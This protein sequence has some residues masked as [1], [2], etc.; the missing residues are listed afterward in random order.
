M[1]ISRE[2]FVGPFWPCTK[3]HVLGLWPKGSKS[4]PEYVCGIMYDHT[5]TSAGEI[6]I[7]R[8]EFS[9]IIEPGSR[10]APNHS[11]GI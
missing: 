5:R 4:P 3:V 1:L 7:T 2:Q 10:T 9:K 8:A 6:P 11:E